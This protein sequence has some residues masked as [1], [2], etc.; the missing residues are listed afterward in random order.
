MAVPL[1]RSAKALEKKMDEY[2]A[3]MDEEKTPYTISGLAL[4]LGMYDT[5]LLWK[6]SS[7]PLFEQAVK[8][9]K[10]KIQNSID[11]AM[12]NNKS[13]HGK[14]ISIPGTIFYAKNALHYRDVVENQGDKQISISINL[15]IPNN[16]SNNDDNYKVVNS[17]PKQ[18]TT[19]PKEIE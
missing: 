2:F 18:V 15:S 10:L 3:K 13:I 4:H 6:Y 5:S 19:K 1:Y 11:V 17:T 16:T 12:M 7:K 9:A 8:K 14:A